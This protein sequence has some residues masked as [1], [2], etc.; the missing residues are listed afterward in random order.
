MKESES[1]FLKKLLSTFKVEAADHIKVLSSG[2]IELEKI[3]DAQK[4]SEIVEKV[5]REA[6]SLKGASRAV[7]ISGIERICQS[8]ENI[9][10][11]IKKKSTG[12]STELLDLLHN[13]VDTLKNIL[14]GLESESPQSDKAG[15]DSIVYKLESYLKDDK[16]T[17]SRKDILTKSPER[18]KVP[19]HS[20]A[21]AAGTVRVAVS[22]LDSLFLQ[23]EE[24]VSTKLFLGQRAAD[25]VAITSAA[26]TW[27]KE[28]SKI[29]SSLRSL[30][31]TVE[32][33]DQ[34]NNPLVRSHLKKILE[35][36]EWNNIHLRSLEDK[37]SAAARAALHDQRAVSLMVD[38]LLGEAKRTL[39]F[40]FTS[41]LEIFPKFVRDLSRD[42][43]KN[44]EL[45]I[46][47]AEIEIDRRILEEI[48]DPL[49][50]LVRNCIDHGIESPDKRKQKK[51]PPV[52]KV[53]INVAQKNGD[54]V[55]ITISDDGAGIDGEKIRSA[56]VKNKILQAEEAKKLTV[57]ELHSLVFQTG[58]STSPIIT[59][60][61]GRGLGLAI[62]REKVEKLGGNV[63]FD[64]ELNTGTT[65]HIILPLTLATYR[66]LL[67]KVN[68]LNFIIPITNIKQ[69]VSVNKNE[70]RSV[71]NRET[72][73]LNGEVLSF[74]KMADALELSIKQQKNNS[75]D[76]FLAVVLSA[77]SKQAAF[78]VDE[79]L[80]EQEVLVKGLGPQLSRVR[81]IAGAAVMGSGAVVP[82]LNI[83]DLIK[84]SLKV[85]PK[86]KGDTAAPKV[87]EENKK[88]VLVVEDSI[89]ARSLLKNILESSGYVV[90]TAVDGVDAFT[91]LRTGT[92]DIVISDVDMP[93]MNGFDLTAKI[94]ADKKTAEIPVIL[95]TAL[96][97]REDKERGIDV[98]A[99]AYI[100]KSS[101]D[102]GNLLGAIKRL[103]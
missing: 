73:F 92:F 25:L 39:M 6:H 26:N 46:E 90:S 98:G 84:S 19:V 38:D 78:L 8:M 41:L 31:H 94:R 42:Q 83:H 47:G 1:E 11:S 69:V 5:F 101:F 66:G 86:V 40:S 21:A 37:I 76:T 77:G 80:H 34:Q 88:S 103:L 59:D 99:N 71:E 55:E 43:N 65:F 51:K 10:S 45:E 18:K 72:I 96:E 89:T 91:Q 63:S 62:V 67:V 68:E 54:K 13:A 15:I 14:S 28:W 27:K 44:V 9:F 23:A 85:S 53:K 82:V 12:I 49:I 57:Q 52:G 58:I 100:V 29:N 75:S 3:T 102:Q 17:A 64:T 7:N 97:S 33:D 36:T 20:E 56:V 79:I 60:V 4:Q 95:V 61:S 74:V 32:K 35:F 48:K 30:Q 2:L 93:R 87:K 16:Q 50:H 70:I 24:M 81:N 22:K